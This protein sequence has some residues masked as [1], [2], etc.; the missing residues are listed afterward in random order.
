M[1]E[2]SLG[3]ASQSDRSSGSIN[4]GRKGEAMSSTSAGT[5][6]GPS[7]YGKRIAQGEGEEMELLAAFVGLRRRLVAAKGEWFLLLRNYTVNSASCVPSEITDVSPLDILAP[8]LALIRSP[9]TSGPITSLALTALNSICFNILPLYLPASP[10]DLSSDLFTAPPRPQ[11]G[12]QLGL[13][14]TTSALARC[15]FP[16]SSPAQDELV[17]SRLL[18]VTETIISGPLERELTDEGVCEMLEVGLG[19]GG[20]A[21]LGGQSPIHLHR[22]RY[23][24]GSN[25]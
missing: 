13:A 9:L 25:S 6:S 18:R 4:T 21:R 3:S 15:R 24:L 2:R 19:M 1:V 23:R 8:F 20:R 12:L 14:A 16:S 10:E 5:E 17:L 11:T 22:A 7:I